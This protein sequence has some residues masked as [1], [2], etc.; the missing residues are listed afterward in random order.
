MMTNYEVKNYDD[1]RDS[2]RVRL[3]D[4]KS[5]AD[6]L[7]D[8]IYEPMGCGYALVAYMEL[9]GS[10]AAGGIA[11]VPKSFAQIEGASKRLIMHDAMVGSMT[12]EQPRLCPIHDMLFGSEADNLFP[13]TGPVEIEAG[14][15]LVL[16]SDSGRLGAS[17]LYYPG[18]AKHLG[19]LVGGDYFVLPSSV[20]EVLILPDRGQADPKELA[21]M[22]QQIN[23]AEVSP[24]ERLGN[25]VLHF[26]S[27]LQKLQVAA[28]MDHD[29]DR[30]K[31]RG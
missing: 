29:K 6:K 23:E 28:D 7:Q 15:P 24:Q 3:M 5:N 2:L 18:V 8:L 1:I 13:E 4:M 10:L 11:N 17:V 25:K 26:R 16:T 30:G 19:D 21:M 14:M 22:V 9:P 31:E 27:D 12:A 20:H